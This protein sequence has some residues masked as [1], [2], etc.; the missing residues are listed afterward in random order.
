LDIKN[1]TDTCVFN[2]IE[3]NYEQTTLVIHVDDTMI[4]DDQ[5]IDNII[6]E[7]EKLYPGLTK[8]RGKV[9]NDIGMTFNYEEPGKVKITMEGFIRD[10]LDTCKESIGISSFPGDHKLFQ[11]ADEVNNPLLPENLRKFFHSVVAKLLLS[12]ESRMFDPLPRRRDLS[13]LACVV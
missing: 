7:I 3:N 5:N 13:T 10:L 2:R 6:N 12:H 11:I 8:I 9:L 1:N 4:T